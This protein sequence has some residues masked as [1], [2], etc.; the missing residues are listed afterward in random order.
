V[1]SRQ[2][3]VDPGGADGGMHGSFLHHRAQ[4]VDELGDGLGGRGLENEIAAAA[5]HH[6]RRTRPEPPGPGPPA[7]GEHA[8]MQADQQLPI[9]PEGLVV[10]APK[11]EAHGIPVAT[12]ERGVFLS[13]LGRAV[14]GEDPVNLLESDGHAFHRRG[15]GDGL[16]LQVASQTTRPR[17]P[18]GAPVVEPFLPAVQLFR[19]GQHG[20]DAKHTRKIIPG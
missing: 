7:P 1:N 6:V 15:G 5:V 12:D 4:A 9:P 11:D 19:G 8:V 13:R 3:D 20:D 2:G 18:D 10:G 14:P 17:P 16:R